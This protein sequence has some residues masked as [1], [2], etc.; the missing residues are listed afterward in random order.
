MCLISQS[1][2]ICSLTLTHI[3]PFQTGT[4]YCVKRLLFDTTPPAGGWA[5]PPFHMIIS[6]IKL[7]SHTIN[8]YALFS[9]I[10]WFI[11]QLKIMQW[12]PVKTPNSIFNLRYRRWMEVTV[13]TPVCLLLAKKKNFSIVCWSVCLS[14]RLFV[15][16][17][18]VCCS[19]LVVR[20]EPTVLIATIWIFFRW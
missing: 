10:T 15:C 6:L 17:L 5:S 9:G 13:F 20:L 12:S 19:F 16:F 1:R 7:S 8:I 2:N 11:H 14:K 3:S 4:H 18:F